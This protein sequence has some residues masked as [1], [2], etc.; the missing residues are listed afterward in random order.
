MRKMAIV[1]TSL[2]MLGMLSVPAAA[3]DLRMTFSGPVALPGVTLPE[4]SYVFRMVAPRV[5]QVLS[6]D[7]KTAYAMTMTIPVARTEAAKEV[8]VT[9]KEAPAGEP[10]VLNG[11]FMPWEFAG[12]ELVFPKPSVLNIIYDY[13]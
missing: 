11:W 7:L 6:G 9:L 4:G 10:P 12:H 1:L 8:K 2:G 3:A 13:C 5:V